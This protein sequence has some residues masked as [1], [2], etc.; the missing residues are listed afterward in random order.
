MPKDWLTLSWKALVARGLVA[1]VFG[2]AAM[3]WPIETAVALAL[4]WGVWA[5]VEGVGSL[6]QAFQ[7]GTSGWARF[8]LIAMGVIA[9][10]AAFFAIF[11]PAVTAV[12]LTWILGIWLIVRGVFELVGAFATS[13]V[14]PRWLLVL[15]ALV[16][17][18]LGVL[19]VAN[20]GRAAVGVAFVLGLTAL[21]WGVVF[22]VTGFIVRKNLA[23]GPVSV[24]TSA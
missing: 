17:F 18:V 9:F 2:I 19:F 16:D 11:S 22:L 24:P 6:A 4:L 1:I 21:L 10:V 3:V 12:T 23:D 20:P 5:L 8:G 15:G 13:T 14:V 7:P